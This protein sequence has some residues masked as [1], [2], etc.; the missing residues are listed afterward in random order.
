[1]MQQFTQS[2]GVRPFGVSL[3]AAG[4]DDDGPQLLQVCWVLAKRL[5]KTALVT[6][7][8]GVVARTVACVIERVSDVGN[9]SCA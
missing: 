2:G 9:S 7:A 1:M 3:L 5:S 4:Y 6:R 8:P